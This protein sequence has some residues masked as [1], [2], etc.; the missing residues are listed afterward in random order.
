MLWTP[1][2]VSR[3]GTDG[4]CHLRPVLFDICALD[5]KRPRLIIIQLRL[6]SKTPLCALPIV[7]AIKPSVAAA[8]SPAAQAEGAA[9]GART[10]SRVKTPRLSPP[11][12]QSE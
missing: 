6:A 9:K 11:F 8:A 12:L 2:R 1:N 5:L 10:E 7:S 3:N 4:R